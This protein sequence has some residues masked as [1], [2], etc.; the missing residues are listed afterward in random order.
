MF[1]NLKNI[2]FFFIFYNFSILFLFSISF[3]AALVFVI[4]FLVLSLDLIFF[5]FYTIMSLAFILFIADL[6]SFLA[7]EFNALNFPQSTDFT[8][9]THFDKL[10][11]HL[12]KDIFIFW[13]FLL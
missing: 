11:F 7:Y 3:V 2:K 4:Y 5:S 9:S 13:R 12:F 1:A 10:Y 6:S 8:S